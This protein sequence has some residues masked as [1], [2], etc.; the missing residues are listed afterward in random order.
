MA[1]AA[2]ADY[3][4]KQNETAADALFAWVDVK[5]YSTLRELI[6]SRLEVLAPL[7]EQLEKVAQAGIGDASQVAAAERTVNMIRV[8]EKMF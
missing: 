3:R 2:L 6:Q 5:R 1:T 8:T 4:V 7:I